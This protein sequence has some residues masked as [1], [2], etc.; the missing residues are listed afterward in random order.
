VEDLQKQ[1]KALGYYQ[2]EIDGQFGP[3]TR[4]AVIA[5]QRNNGL[6]ADGIAGTETLSVLYSQDAGPD[7][8]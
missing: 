2:G 6:D 1:L 7:V 4:D 3:G 8:E 5:F